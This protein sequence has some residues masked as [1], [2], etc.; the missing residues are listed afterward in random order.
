MWKLIE[1]VELYKQNLVDK[2]PKPKQPESIGVGTQRFTLL[3]IS[4]GFCFL[5]TCLLLF[6]CV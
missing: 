3:S 2:L 5:P 1:S 4:V 6:M